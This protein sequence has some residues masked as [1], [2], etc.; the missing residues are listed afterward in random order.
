MDKQRIE[1]QFSRNSGY[2]TQESQIQKQMAQSLAQMSPD[3]FNPKSLFEFGAG[4]GHLTAQLHHRWPQA[5]YTALDISH[6]M[7]SQQYEFSEAVQYIQGDIE[8][9]SFTQKYDLIA[10][11]ATLQWLGDIGRVLQKMHKALYPSGVVMLGTFGPSTLQELHTAYSTA[12]GVGFKSPV[13]YTSQQELYALL[14]AVGFTNVQVHST[15]LYEYHSS[16]SHLLKHLKRMGV[17]SIHHSPAL[18]RTGLQALQSEYEA[19]FG[20]VKGLQCTWECVLAVGRVC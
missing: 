18:T 15:C 3:A 7:V 11:N 10:S 6:G 12:Q 2:Y 20:G 5:K 19:N 4:T 16:V 17:T 9:Y 8:Q 14:T 13:R 1:R